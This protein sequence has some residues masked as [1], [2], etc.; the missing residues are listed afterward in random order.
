MYTC[1]LTAA[2]R[3][4]DLRH[5]TKRERKHLCYT[6][7][8]SN[9][10]LRFFC[11]VSCAWVGSASHPGHGP[12]QSAGVHA[13]PRLPMHVPDAGCLPRARALVSSPAMVSVQ[14]RSDG[15]ANAGAPAV[16]RAC[17][18]ACAGAQ[19]QQGGPGAADSCVEE[20]R[21]HTAKQAH[22]RARTRSLLKNTWCAWAD[23]HREARRCRLGH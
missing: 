17:P 5:T 15:V 18:A 12:R 11:P 13:R 3:S 19:G 20:G 22:A 23:F 9:F 1:I 4:P 14:S 7:V 16:R 10:V 21:A 2:L 8:T 6:V